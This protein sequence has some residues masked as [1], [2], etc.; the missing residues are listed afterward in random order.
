MEGRV[1]LVGVAT[2]TVKLRQVYGCDHAP[3]ISDRN[4]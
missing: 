4:K 2:W 3:F 1:Y